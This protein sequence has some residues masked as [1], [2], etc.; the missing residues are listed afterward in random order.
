MGLHKNYLKVGQNASNQIFGI[1]RVHRGS[2]PLSMLIS[3]GAKF[4][5]SKYTFM[6]IIQVMMVHNFYF[7]FYL[8]FLTFICATHMRIELWDETRDTLWPERLNESNFFLFLSQ[9]V[10]HSLSVDN[11]SFILHIFET[12]MSLGKFIAVQ[13]LHCLFKFIFSS[14]KNC[15]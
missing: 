5:S 11:N 10:K 14:K 1:P 2:T 3:Y 6:R 4:N 12:H 7:F 15:G 9:C 13:F 8:R